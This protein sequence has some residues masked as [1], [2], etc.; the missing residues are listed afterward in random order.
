MEPYDITFFVFVASFFTFPF[1]F[2]ARSGGNARRIW[3]GLQVAFFVYW[4]SVF[5]GS[6]LFGGLLRSFAVPMN[7]DPEGSIFMFYF[8]VTPIYLAFIIL[9]LLSFWRNAKHRK[10]TNT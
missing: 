3:L 2:L 6:F 9:E 1:Y 5:F 10:K 7:S 4:N 8:Y